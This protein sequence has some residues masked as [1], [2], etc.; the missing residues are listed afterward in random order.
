[1]EQYQ[2]QKWAYTNTDNWFLTKVKGTPM[3]KGYSF[4]WASLYKKMSLN[5]YKIQ[6][7]NG[8]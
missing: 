8:S 7:K 4:D 1:M 6:L 2:V 5:P 3:E